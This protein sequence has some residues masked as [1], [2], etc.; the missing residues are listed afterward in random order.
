MAKMIKMCMAVECWSWF[1]MSGTPVFK[2]PTMVAVG[3]GPGSAGWWWWW[4]RGGAL[5]T[6]YWLDPMLKKIIFTREASVD[7]LF[8]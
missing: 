5:W 2:S 1:S 4:W 3:G 6:I 8:Y 7:L